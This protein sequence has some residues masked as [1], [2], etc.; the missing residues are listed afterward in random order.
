MKQADGTTCPNSEPE[1]LKSRTEGDTIMKKI[2]IILSLT[3][4]FGMFAVN[5]F[6]YQRPE[7]MVSEYNDFETD[8]GDWTNGLIS[9]CTGGG[10]ITESATTV[11]ISSDTDPDHG[12]YLVVNNA[13]DLGKTATLMFDIVTARVQ[14]T[15]N[16]QAN[17]EVIA[18][19]YF[20]FEFD[21][22]LPEDASSSTALDL[23]VWDTR[24]SRSRSTLVKIVPSTGKVTAGKNTYTITKG[25]W[26]K[27]KLEAV[28]GSALQ[29]F[30]IADDN[31]KELFVSNINDSSKYLPK[32]LYS[33]VTFSQG[34]ADC[35]FY[36]DNT[37][38]YTFSSEDLNAG[39][40]IFRDDMQSYSPSDYTEDSTSWMPSWSEAKKFNVWIV[41]PTDGA[42]GHPL[43]MDRHA[44]FYSED[45]NT[46]IRLK[47]KGFDAYAN[48]LGF[49]VDAHNDVT[50]FG[51]A[52]NPKS[53][54]VGTKVR[55]DDVSSRND[56]KISLIEEAGPDIVRTVT[57]VSPYS[58]TV[59]LG[60]GSS[61]STV[62]GLTMESGKW[63]DI[64]VIYNAESDYQRVEITDITD[65]KTQ[66]F[67][68][69]SGY[70]SDDISAFDGVL[71][72]CSCTEDTVADF[73][74]INIYTASKSHAA[75]FYSA[76][77][78]E[79]EADAG[80]IIINTSA[81]LGDFSS[82][83]V[84]FRTDE[85][86]EIPADILYD[87]ANTV[88]VVP[89]VSLKE[90][91]RLQVVF[92]KDIP[93]GGEAPKFDSVLSFTVLID[94]IYMDYSLKA[95]GREVYAASD[96]KGKSNI[97]CDITSTNRTAEDFNGMYVMTIVDK[98]NELKGICAENV[99]LS[100]SVPNSDVSLSLPVPDNGEDLEVYIMLI[101]NFQSS[102]AIA[103][104][105]KI[106]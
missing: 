88:T 60:T 32:L 45:D 86:K 106:H 13:G 83:M 103:K 3:L 29:R 52:E 49:E 6:A 65:G 44:G 14:A 30:I 68:G 97:T 73:D 11:A 63:Y 20:G 105:I 47:S 7:N 81:P 35:E 84:T 57:T 31:G 39:K 104:Y 25:T 16:S 58:N 77:S 19:D 18:G 99:S 74:D 21:F 37:K 79:L 9:G 28:V 41:N 93:V 98:S 69:A 36:L 95:D 26:Y 87:G 10:D 96:L 12:K 90:N 54:V 42:G 27:M 2:S 61:A 64:E 38:A 50:V 71:F 102:K 40:T 56:I 100:A 80:E 8:V 17:A 34:G 92:S 67:D 24:H 101:D 62:G 15:A 51:T 53:F 23:M 48:R 82:D 22:K 43:G 46:F 94:E 78:Y 4:I 76:D 75:P 89:S 59:T 72:E 66:V 91:A 55:I 85:N 70:A 1:Y 5:T 33:F